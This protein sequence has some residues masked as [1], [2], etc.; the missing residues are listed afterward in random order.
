MSNL[1]GLPPSALGRVAAQT[2][3]LEIAVRVVNLPNDLKNNAAPVKVQGVVTGQNSDGSI[4]V[5]TDRGTIAVM[6][7][8]R[9]SLPTGQRLELELPAGRSPQQATLRPAPT[10][11]APLP[12]SPPAPTLAGHLAAAL[13]LDRA[14]PIKATE[15]DEALKAAATKL[16]DLVAIKLPSAALQAGQNLRLIPIPPGQ[17]ATVPLQPGQIAALPQDAILAALTTMIEFTSG[18]SAGCKSRFDRFAGPDEH[19]TASSLT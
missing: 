13:K 11:T 5:Q 12:T 16:A 19:G 1:S 7:R 18:A 14:T 2:V 8:D 9:Q 15:I 6:L 17:T 10:S 4:Q 3:A